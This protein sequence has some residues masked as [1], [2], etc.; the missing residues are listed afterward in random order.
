MHRNKV[1]YSI[2]SSAR[3]RKVCGI[4]RPSAFAVLR[5][6]PGQPPDACNCPI[7]YATAYPPSFERATTSIC[8]GASMTFTSQSLAIAVVQHSA[9]AAAGRTRIL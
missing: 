7:V 4:S 9:H 1:T 6:R 5:L 3:A 2:T 8:G